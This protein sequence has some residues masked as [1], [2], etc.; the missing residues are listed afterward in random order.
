MNQ[1][2]TTPLIL[3]T[4]DDGIRST[5]L[6]AAAEACIG[7]GDLLI[8]APAQQQSAVGRAKPP[9]SSGRIFTE[10]LRIDGVQMIGYAI[11]ATPAQVVEHALVELADRTPALVVSGINFGENIGE[12]ITTS[13]TV[14]AALEAASFEVPA[15]AVS[16]QSDPQHYFTHDADLDFLTAAHFVRQLAQAILR[17]GLPPGVD[18]LKLDVP[19]HATPA[20]P[21]R[22]TRLSRQRYFY[23][24]ARARQALS[25]PAPLDFVTRADPATLE[26]DSD[27][28]AVAVD[29]VISV[30][31]LVRD[32]SATIAEQRLVAWLDGE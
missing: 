4:N 25:D 23:P 2:P 9:S 7:L 1:S 12:G 27:V 14:G 8:A 16:L 30:T 11:E 29:Q 10:Q 21:L 20:T 13:G 22:W 5:G 24:V 19:S 31:P 3:I 32:L 26:P 6:L 17:H 28:R 18:L 15:L